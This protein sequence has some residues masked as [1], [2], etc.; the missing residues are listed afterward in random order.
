MEIEYK[1]KNNHNISIEQVFAFFQRR[2]FYCTNIELVDMEAKYF[3]DSLNLLSKEKIT[4]RCRKENQDYYFNIK[5]KQ[6]HQQTFFERLEVEFILD[7]SQ[8]AKLL[9]EKNV[10]VSDI[11]SILRTYIT[12]ADNVD[13]NEFNMI[14][15]TINP[16]LNSIENAEGYFIIK[17]QNRFSRKKFIAIE[18]NK[19]EIEVAFDTGILAKDINFSEIEFEIKKDC[20]KQASLLIADLVKEFD[21]EAEVLTKFERGQV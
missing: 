10:L 3:S 17:S 12:K 1:F 13:N 11:K 4:L 14:I 21:L 9:S 18:D 8:V 20:R 16:L 6:V 2:Q 7:D 19:T 5:I 15:N